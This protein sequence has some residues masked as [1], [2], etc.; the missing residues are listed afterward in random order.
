M[1][2]TTRYN[3][4]LAFHAFQIASEEVCR[5]KTKKAQWPFGHRASS[6][7][8]LCYGPPAETGSNAQ[9]ILGLERSNSTAFRGAVNLKRAFSVI[10]KIR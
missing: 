9:I 3:Q 8:G 7:L 2:E 6:E 10:G 1:P 5:P 4:S